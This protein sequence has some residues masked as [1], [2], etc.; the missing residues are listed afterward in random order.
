MRKTFKLINQLCKTREDEQKASHVD[1]PKRSRQERRRAS[2]HKS[3]KAANMASS[4]KRLKSNN[5]KH[6]KRMT[7]HVD[8]DDS[9][10]ND[11]DDDSDKSTDA[12]DAEILKRTKSLLSS[13]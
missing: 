2:H 8:D 9:D 6:V 7:K 5:G 10:D 11:S 1:K 13:E 3:D 4:N 12:D